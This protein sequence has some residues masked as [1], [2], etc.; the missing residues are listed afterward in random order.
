MSELT[1]ILTFLLTII[2]LLIG[3]SLGKNQSALPPNYQK[4]ITQIL[5]RAVKDNNDV[6]AVERPNAQDNF[7]RDNPKIA[8]EHKEMSK[9]FEELN[10]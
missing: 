5:T 7:Y 9:A 2:S 8:Q 3:F 4:K 6:G 10:K 1:I